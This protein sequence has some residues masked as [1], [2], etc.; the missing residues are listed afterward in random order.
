MGAVPDP[1]FGLLNQRE[2]PTT[3]FVLNCGYERPSQNR[4]GGE[5]L[6]MI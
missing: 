1:K 6:F 3:D 5:V 4:F 2:V